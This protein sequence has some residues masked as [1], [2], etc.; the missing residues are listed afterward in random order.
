MFFFY[1]LFNPNRSCTFRNMCGIAGLRRNM[2]CVFYSILYYIS[3]ITWGFTECTSSYS[4]RFLQLN[5]VSQINVSINCIPPRAREV[6]PRDMEISVTTRGKHGHNDWDIPQIR[7]LIILSYF[8][9]IAL[10]M[11]QVKVVFLTYRRSLNIVDC[12][13]WKTM[14]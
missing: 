8:D 5:Y 14:S 12:P 11:Y 3:S 2:H 10:D 4:S 13:C 6:I 7:S 9:S 1:A